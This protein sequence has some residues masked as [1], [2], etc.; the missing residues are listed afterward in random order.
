M[1]K[2]SHQANYRFAAGT[3]LISTLFHPIV[4]VGLRSM[5]GESTFTLS[6]MARVIWPETLVFGAILAVILV[7]STAVIR[8]LSRREEA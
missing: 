1:S 8:R 5:N 6:E 3:T 4:T 2:M 7:G